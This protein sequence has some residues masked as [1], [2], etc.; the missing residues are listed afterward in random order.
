MMPTLDPATGYLPAGVHAAS[1]AEV[2]AQFSINSH[3]AGQLSGLLSALKNLAGAGCKT[4]LLDGSFVSEKV[5]P[6]DYDAAWDI[7][8][9]DPGKLDPVLLDFK[10]HRAAMKAK[11]GGEFFPASWDAAPG[12]PYTDFFQTDRNGVPKGIVSIDLGSLP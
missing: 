3:R 8:G 12:I 1:W 11:Y 7:A 5:L 2:V 10:N 6:G 4:F 9:V